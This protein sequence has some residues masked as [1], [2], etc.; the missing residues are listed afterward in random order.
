MLAAP[1][2]SGWVFM[3]PGPSGQGP[4]WCSHDRPRGRLIRWR[5]S[6]A[7]LVWSAGNSAI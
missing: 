5:V 3:S 4:D 6:D 1:P 7:R 2:L